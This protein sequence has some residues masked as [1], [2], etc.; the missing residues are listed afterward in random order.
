MF[1][2]KDFIKI[3]GKIISRYPGLHYMIGRVGIVNRI[4]ST[5]AWIE[6]TSDIKGH[7]HLIEFS[8]LDKITKKEFIK[9][10]VIEKL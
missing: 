5:F 7:R 6:F 8:F 10:A 3:N 4:E 1:K 9:N 2:K